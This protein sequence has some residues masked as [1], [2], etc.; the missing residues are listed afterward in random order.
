MT[1]FGPA[2]ANKGQ[3]DDVMVVCRN[4]L[5]LRSTVRPEYWDLRFRGLLPQLVLR[6]FL[7]RVSMSSARFI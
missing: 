7:S 4:H 6:S 5:D 2:P 1:V 3:A